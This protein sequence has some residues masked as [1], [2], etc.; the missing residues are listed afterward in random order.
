MKKF[1]LLMADDSRE[2][3]IKFKNRAK[4]KGINAS[5]VFDGKSLLTLLS[6]MTTDIIVIDDIM[7]G[8]NCID[9]LKQIYSMNI[10]NKPKIVVTLSYHSDDFIRRA[11]LFGVD[12]FV[13]KNS[14]IDSIVDKIIAFADF[15]NENNTNI[16]P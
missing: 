7:P 14:G 6:R 8:P 4:R 11:A 10:P 12:L 15:P 16:I 9:I 13:P 5:A 2:Y 1:K 3:C